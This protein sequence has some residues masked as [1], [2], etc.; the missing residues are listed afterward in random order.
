MGE[1]PEVGEVDGQPCTS[2][3]GTASVR[4]ERRTSACTPA[5]SGVSTTTESAASR[6]STAR[7]SKR[8]RQWSESARRWSGG[9]P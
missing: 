8:C 9:T 7:Q 4:V 2:S 1:R 6:S 5:W 3:S